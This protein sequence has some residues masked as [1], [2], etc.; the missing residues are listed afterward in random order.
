MLIENKGNA[1]SIEKKERKI[2]KDASESIIIVHDK[3]TRS[4]FR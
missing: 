3:I 2:R 1:F 4:R